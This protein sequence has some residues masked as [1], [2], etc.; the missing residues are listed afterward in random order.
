MQEKKITNIL[1]NIADKKDLSPE[2]LISKLSSFLEKHNLL[3][4]LP[5]ISSILEKNYKKALERE[6]ITIRSRYALD[7]EQ[8]LEIKKLISL[9]TDTKV[10]E[11]ID[12]SVIGGFIA[13]Q[14][15]I[16]YD[17]SLA[18]QIENFNNSLKE[19]KI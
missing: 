12:K 11:V 17:G 15:G 2:E 6:T 3:S 14:N 19:V 10:K 5:K 1:I 13:Q 16:V 9:N 7:S 4:L 18:K 8:I